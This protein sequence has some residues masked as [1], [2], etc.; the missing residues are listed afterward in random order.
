MIKFNDKLENLLDS[1][2]TILDIQNR[3][4]KHNLFFFPIS[5]F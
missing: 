1:T 5:T 3:A 2:K 4:F